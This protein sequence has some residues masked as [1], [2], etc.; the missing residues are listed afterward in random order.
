MDVE[1]VSRLRAVIFRLARQLNATATAEGLT[2]TQT[3][4]LGLVAF[5]GPL[6]LAELTEL[7]GVN[8]TMLSRV[9]R[10][11]D[12]DG[13]IRRLPDPTDLRAARVEITP[14]GALVSDRIR[15]LRTQAV[16][17]CLER[18]PDRH[19]KELLAAL[20]ALEALEEKLKSAR[21]P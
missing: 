5:R 14:A 8:P 19:S 1:D 9:V 20:P 15:R 7:E 17:D 10:K 18:M 16:S 21:T 2:P 4:V 12:E 6:A 3:S 13:L 11:L